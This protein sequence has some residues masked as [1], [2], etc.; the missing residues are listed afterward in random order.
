MKVIIRIQ[1]QKLHENGLKD[2][3][4]YLRTRGIE[5]FKS[6]YSHFGGCYFFEV[7]NYTPDKIAVILDTPPDQFDWNV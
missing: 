2:P 4:D 3:F 7:E 5:V 6:A 1:V